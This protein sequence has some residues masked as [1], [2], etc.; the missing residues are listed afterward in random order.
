M[1]DAEFQTHLIATLAR[2]QAEERA[3][4]AAALAAYQAECIASWAGREANVE[5][6]R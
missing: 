1:T 3:R 5:D 2:Q 6:D 4:D